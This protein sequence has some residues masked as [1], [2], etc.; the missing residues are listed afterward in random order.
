MNNLVVNEND[1]LIIKLLHYFVTEQNYSPIVLKGANNEIWLEKLNGEYKIVRL[2]SNYIHNN[3]Q[4]N[5]DSYRTE[6][7]IKRIKQKTMSFNMNTLSIYVNLGDNVDI[8]KCDK[9]NID[10]VNIKSV[11]ELNNFSF[12]IEEFPTITKMTQ[13]KEKGI[14]LFMKLTSDIGKKN[15]EDAKMAEDIFT[16]KEPIVTKIL[17]LINAV[18]FLLSFV[19]GQNAIINLFANYG[20]NVKNG[21]IYRLITGAFVH[22]AMLHFLFN[23]Y[24]LYII[25]PQIE[26]FFGRWR[27]LTIYIGSAIV[28]SLLSVMFNPG[29]VSIGASGAI[30]GLLG[31]LLYF[32]YHYRVYLD[33]VIKSQI[34]PLILLNLFIGFMSTGIDNAAH[35]GGLIGGVLASMAVGVK[36]KSTRLEK[37]NGVI[38]SSIFLAFLI[39]MVF[40]R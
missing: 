12:V 37:T 1:E 6:Q 38:M 9:P 20:P 25:G 23:M 39:Y 17:L 34:V 18:I 24:A 5:V 15:E 26:N 8:K 3:E 28:G 35:I 31:S 29:T 40:F 10:C 30:F 2:V 32:G 22:V 14:E 11:D 27:Y 33:S 13:Y 21:E 19:L 4:L 36:Y 7:I 16:K